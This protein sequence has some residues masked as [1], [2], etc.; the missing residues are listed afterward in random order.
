M[1][2]T[3]EKE[4]FIKCLKCGNEINSSTQKKLIFCKCGAI[5]VDGC[6]EYIRINGNKKDYQQILKN[7]QL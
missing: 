2:K 7:K 4:L 6:S 3:K 5:S 1:Q